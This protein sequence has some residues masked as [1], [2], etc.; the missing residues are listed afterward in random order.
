MRDLLRLF[1]HVQKCPINAIVR[2]S[3]GLDVI[4]KEEDLDEDRNNSK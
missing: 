2:K 4:R 1:G 3:E